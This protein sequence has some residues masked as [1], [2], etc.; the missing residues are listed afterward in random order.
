MAR[1]PPVASP[2]ERPIL[3][4]GPMAIAVLAGLKTQTRRIVREP[5]RPPRTPCPYGAPGDRLWVRINGAESWQKNPWVW[6][7]AFR[8]LSLDARRTA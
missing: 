3:F 7:V 6:V 5:S 8:R 1:T 4:S 2:R